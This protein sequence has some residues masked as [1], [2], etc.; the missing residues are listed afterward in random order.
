VT[1]I[2]PGHPEQNGRHERMHRRSSKKLCVRQPLAFGLSRGRFMPSERSL[3]R[4]AFTRPS[5]TT[6]LRLDT[7]HRRESSPVDCLQSSTHLA[8][9]CAESLPAVGFGGRALWSRSGM[10]SR[11]SP[12]EFSSRMGCTRSSSLTSISAS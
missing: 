8:S 4:S 1:R 3:T 12:S 10:L 11:G 9:A 2:E 7:R 5:M 6:R